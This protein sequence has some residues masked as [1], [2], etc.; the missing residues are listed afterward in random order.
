MAP[1]ASRLPS[2]VVLTQSVYEPP[3]LLDASKRS[4][5]PQSLHP[6]G[7]AAHWHA[8]VS[9]RTK[10][11]HPQR[12]QKQ[13]AEE[14]VGPTAAPETQTPARKVRDVGR[15]AATCAVPPPIPDG[16]HPAAQLSW[17]GGCRRSWWRSARPGTAPT[18]ERCRPCRPP[19]SK[20]RQQ[21]EPHTVRAKLKEQK[22]I[23]V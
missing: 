8:A 1:P 17:Q 20:S 5:A 9:W 12:E 21:Q 16:G 14:A 23:E 15:L 22:P 4:M 10:S 11:S 18:A 13:G 19:P 6:L 7:A 2:V 3:P